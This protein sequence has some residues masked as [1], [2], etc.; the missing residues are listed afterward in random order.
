MHDKVSI[1]CAL[2]TPQWKQSLRSPSMQVGDTWSL[3][4]TIA[5]LDRQNRKFPP[6]MIITEAKNAHFFMCKRTAFV[7]Q[8]L[9]DFVKMTLT[10]AIDCDLC[11]TESFC[12]K[13]DSSRVTIFLNVTR[14][15][16]ES[17]KVVTRVESLTRVTLSLQISVTYF[18]KRFQS[19]FTVGVWRMYPFNLPLLALPTYQH[20]VW[21]VLILKSGPG[22]SLK[23]HK[24]NIHFWSTILVRMPYFSREWK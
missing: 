4:C 18:I 2:L 19:I 13:R 7:H 14:V 15:E 20:R 21:K 8:K 11:R 12:V 6:T 9:R 17:P 23:H 16:S 22:R 3:K 1:Y 10:R 5:R 24:P